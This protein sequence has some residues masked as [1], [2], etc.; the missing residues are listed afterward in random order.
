[1]SDDVIERA[2]AQQALASDRSVSVFVSAS[3][4]SGKTK[5]LIDRLLRLMLPGPDRAPTPPE[6]ILIDIEVENQASKDAIRNGLSS[7]SEEVRKRGLDPIALDKEI[8]QDNA[9]ADELGLVFDSDPRAVSGRGVSQ[10]PDGPLPS[11]KTG[12]AAPQRAA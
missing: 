11:K 8:A 10:K 2:Q 12:P 4:G 6:R 7:R 3:A 1:M 5:L 9:R